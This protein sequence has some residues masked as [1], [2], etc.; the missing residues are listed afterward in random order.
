MRIAKSRIAIVSGETSRLK[1]V[2]IAGDGA[3]ALGDMA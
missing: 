1:V 2:E 3:V